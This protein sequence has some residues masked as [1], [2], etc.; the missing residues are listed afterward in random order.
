M[1][2]LVDPR[3]IEGRSGRLVCCGQQV[4]VFGEVHPAVLESWG[5]SMPTVACEVD[6]D[7]LG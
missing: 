6:L 5:C 3:F 4:G 1:E 7:M 2:E